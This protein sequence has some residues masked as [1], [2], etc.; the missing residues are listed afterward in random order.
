MLQPLAACRKPHTFTAMTEALPTPPAPEPTC[1]GLGFQPFAQAALFTGLLFAFSRVFLVLPCWG[2]ALAVFGISLVIWRHLSER[3]LFRRRVVLAPLAIEDS[4]LHRILMRAWFARLI[5]FAAAMVAAAL[6]LTFG[7]V[8]TDRQW[9]V[10]AGNALLFPLLQPVIARTFARQIRQQ[11]LDP[12]SRHT[13]AIALNVFVLVSTFMAMD[14]IFGAPDTRDRSLL[15]VFSAAYVSQADGAACGAA[16]FACGFIAGLDAAA[17]HLR[18]IAIPALPDSTLRLVAW[19]LTLLG[20][21]VLAL[22]YSAFLA[23]ATMRIRLSRQPLSQTAKGF[24]FTIAVLA[25]G[26]IMLQANFAGFSAPRVTITGAPVVKQ[27]VAPPCAPHE[28]ISAPLQANFIQRLDATKNAALSRSEAKIRSGLRQNFMQAE[29]RVDG[30]L[31]WYYSVLGEYERLAAMA[32]S[33]VATEVGSELIN[34]LFAGQFN[35]QLSGL[36]K[37][38]SDEVHQLYLG[39]VG[40]SLSSLREKVKADAC[41]ARLFDAARIDSFERD[42]ARA[43]SAATMGVA[44]GTAVTKVGAAATAKLTGKK[45]AQHAASFAA[46]MLAKKGVGAAG[47]FFTGSLICSPGGPLALACGAALGIAT[48]VGADA[49]F[50]NVDEYLNRDEMRHD[51]LMSLAEMEREIGDQLIALQRELIAKNDSSIRAEGEKVFSPLRDGL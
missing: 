51:I 41:I 10:L 36:A 25:V 13:L 7:R 28:Q 35:Q 34:R 29:G 38:A 46:K 20:S 14:L 49:L 19:I 39:L 6:L 40:D 15:A 50:I 9:L 1:L 37:S 21:G 5:A 31:D 30:Y 48:W 8:L 16:G 17:W 44:A 24:V 43:G 11:A 22:T 23:G 33:Q 45:F 12:L 32:G 2:G 47:G 18:E 42:L 3:A 27:P 4:L 26:S